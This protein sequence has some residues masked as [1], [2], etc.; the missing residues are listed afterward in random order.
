MIAAKVTVKDSLGRETG[1]GIYNEQWYYRFEPLAGKRG[2]AGTSEIIE[3]RYV[4]IYNGD[5]YI[6]QGNVEIQV[7]IPNA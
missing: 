6:G 5:Q 1:E 2:S 7:L 4:A 3:K